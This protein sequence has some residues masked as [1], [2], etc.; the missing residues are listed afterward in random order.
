[1]NRSKKIFRRAK[2]VIP[3]GVNSPVRAWKSVGADPLVIRRGK[4]SLIFDADGKR[5]VD[6][7]G[8]W[9]PLILGHAHPTIVRAL[10]RALRD[11]FTFGAPTE[12]EVRLAEAVSRAVPSIESLRLVSSGTEAAMSAIRLARAYTSKRKIIKFDGCYH[13]HSDGLLVRAG[14]GVATLGLP[15]SAGVLGEFARETLIADYNDFKSVQTAFKR[16]EGDIAA[17]IVEPI[18]GNMGV[19]A[20]E[21]GFLRRLREITLRTGALLIFDE[22]ITGFRVALGGAQ[23]IFRVKPDLT[24]LGKVLGG[25]FPLAAFGGAR[26]IMNLLAPSGPVYQAGTLSGNPIAVTAGLKTLELLARNRT[27]EKLEEKA[28]LLESGFR[29]VLA[30]Y[31]IRAALNRVGSMLT[32]FFG[33]D[34]VHNAAEAR[35]ANREQFARYFH[36]MLARGIYLPPAPYEAMFLSLAHSSADIQAA[37]RAFDAWAQSERHLA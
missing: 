12:A 23:Q 16:N 7:V 35:S 30:K 20:P 1:M 34:R 10:H 37:I 25:G 22:V 27:Y 13:G 29:Q 14:S 24:C 3:G 19:I 18:C 9:G 17:V 8:S 2:K 4:G 5:Y 31:R 15:D 11:G 26:K 36:G 32:L 6:L 21:P 28:G 33:V